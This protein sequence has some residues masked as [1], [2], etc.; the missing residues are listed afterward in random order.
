[1]ASRGGGA[2]A[3]HVALSPGEIQ[4]QTQPAAAA[5][6]L[7]RRPLR[8]AAAGR[9]QNEI[10]TDQTSVS[11]NARLPRHFGNG[12]LGC[13]RAQCALVQIGQQL[14]FISAADKITLSTVINNLPK[15]IRGCAPAWVIIR[16]HCQLSPSERSQQF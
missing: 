10:F 2:G 4:A 13:R 7:A 14:V 1:M 11:E 3:A 5:G 9:L 6:P 16:P 8:R 15:L 12:I